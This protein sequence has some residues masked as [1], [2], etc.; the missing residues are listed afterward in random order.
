MK[1]L[2][3]LRLF[4]SKQKLWLM[5]WI[6]PVFKL[7]SNKIFLSK[8]KI[9]LVFILEQSVG[10][11]ECSVSKSGIH[12]EKMFTTE[13]ENFV[14]IWPFVWSENPMSVLKF[15]LALSVASTLPILC[16]W[17]DVHEVTPKQKLNFKHPKK[18]RCTKD[19]P[20]HFVKR[21]KF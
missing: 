8:I 6:N 12:G 4:D 11:Q 16:A 7:F 17:C 18:F 2:V 21:K 14:E 10:L 1:T 15:T 19:V 13:V 9:S 20:L 3:W 5:L